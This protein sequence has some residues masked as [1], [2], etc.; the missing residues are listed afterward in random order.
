MRTGE[1]ER[2]EA[3]R[4]D[5]LARPLVVRGLAPAWPA[6]ERWSFDFL[7]D[8]HGDTEV[9]VLPIEA[10]EVVVDA[11]RRMVG[12]PKPLGDFVRALQSGGPSGHAMA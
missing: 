10:G 5:R 12:R 11:R 7:R 4:W 3:M 1:V 8:V 2:G 6:R 9:P